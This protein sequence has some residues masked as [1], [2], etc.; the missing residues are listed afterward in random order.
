MKK[1]ITRSAGRSAFL[2]QRGEGY[3][4]VLG[5]KVY[6]TFGDKNITLG[7]KELPIDIVG[8]DEINDSDRWLLCEVS[9]AKVFCTSLPSWFDVR[10]YITKNFDMIYEYVNSP[11]GRHEVDRKFIYN[12]TKAEED[13]AKMKRSA[14]NETRKFV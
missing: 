8:T 12:L 5:Y 11:E 10:N 4:E 7:V 6:C 3:G 1:R 14:K 2:V 13:Y 9:T